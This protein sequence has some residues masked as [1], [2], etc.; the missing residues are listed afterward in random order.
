M[1]GFAGIVVLGLVVLCAWGLA[2]ILERSDQAAIAKAREIWRGSV[3]VKIC[4]K[5]KIWQLRDGRLVTDKEE[6]VKDLQ[7]C[8]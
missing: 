7:V 2:S 3:I 6:T 4:G 5:T 1:K 8:S